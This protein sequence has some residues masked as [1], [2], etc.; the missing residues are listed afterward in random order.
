MI[1]VPGGVY[2]TPSSVGDSDA[3]GLEIS[4]HGL[5][6]R[7]WRWSL[8]YRAE[9]VHDNFNSFSAAGGNFIDYEHTTPKHMAKANIGWTHGKWEADAYLGFQSD[10]MGLR[11]TEAGTTLVPV[12]AY[13]TVDGRVAYQLAAIPAT[14]NWRRGYRATGDGNLECSLLTL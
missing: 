12:G 5:M 3:D 2:L 10:V 8:S 4:V 1:S 14:A 7:D 13:V 11:A 9:L 6:G